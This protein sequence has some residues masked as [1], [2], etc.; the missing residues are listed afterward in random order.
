MN[1]VLFRKRLALVGIFLV[2]FFGATAQTVPTGYAVSTLSAPVTN[3]FTTQLTV[4]QANGDLYYSDNL[5]GVLRKIPLGGTSVIVNNSWSTG[6]PFSA[7]DIQYHYDNVLGGAVYMARG[8]EVVR[9]STDYNG[10]YAVAVGSFGNESGS[11]LIG[12]LLYVSDGDH[13]SNT[14]TTVDLTTNSVS[15]LT[16]G[17]LPTFSY[18]SLEYCQA[19]NTLYYGGSNWPTGNLYSVDQTTGVPT[20]ISTSLSSGPGN[21]AVDP[22]GKYAYTADLSGDINRIDLVTG[23]SSPFATG[24]SSNTYALAFGPALGGGYNLYMTT[25]TS[26]IYQISGFG[27]SALNFDGVNDYVISASPIGITGNQPRTVEYWATLNNAYNHHVN[28]GSTTDN[29][30]FG[31]Y[32]TGGFLHFYCFGVTGTF[33][34]NTGFAADNA[35]HHV[36]VT[37]DGTTVRTYVDGLPTPFPTA[38][39]NLTTANGPVYIGV[40]ED[41]SAVTFTNSTIEDVR[42]WNRALCQ[43]EIQAH[44]SCELTG[45]ETGL[46]LYYKFNDGNP[47]ANNAGVTTANDNSPSNNDG[48]LNGPFTLNGTASNWVDATVAGSC[49]AFVAPVATPSSNSP[50]CTGNTINLSADPVTGA[51]YSWTGPNAF[52]SSLQNPTI[53]PATLAD[54]GTYSLTITVAGCTSAVSTT[55]VIVN[56]VPA[57]PTAANDGPVCEGATFNLSTPTV[58]GA[59]YLWTGPNGFTSLDQNPVVTNATPLMS[60]TY[61][62]TVTVA[63]CTSAAGTTNLTVNPT[64]ATPAPSSN[65]PVCTGNTIN[66]STAAVAGATYSW[67]GPNGFTSSLQNPSITNATAA[68]AGTYFVTVTVLGCTSAAGSTTVVVN[69]TPA[70]PT[71]S[72][73]TPVCTGNTINLSTPAVAGATYSWTGPSAFASALQNPT[74]TNATVAMAGTYSVTV[75][76]SGC[77]SAVGTTAVVVNAT[78]ATPA[79]SSNTPV[80]TGNTI[81]L[82][83]SAVA[84]ATYSWTGP[85]SFASSVQNPSITNAT[86]AMAGTYSVTVTVNGC[87]SAVGTTAVVIN[88]TPA[89]PTASS[90]TPVCTGNTINLSTPAV[91]GATYSWT[92]P[93]AFASALQN[94]TRTNATLAMAGTYSVTVTVTGCTSAVGT[95]AVVVNPTPATPA[96]SSNTPVCTGN[97]INLSTSAVAGATYSWT[98]PNSFVSSVQN[99]SITNATVAM[100]G[101][102]SVTVTVNGCTSAVGT[103]AVVVNPTPATPT[104]SSN[105]P[106]CTGNTIN[107]STP[108]VAGATYSWTGPNSFASSVQNPS[109]T[110]ATLA[111]GGTYSVTVTVTGCTSAIGTTA[112]VVNPTPATPAPSSNTPV[113]TG[114]TIN[115]ST[116]AVAGATY[117]WTGPNSFVSSVQNPSITNATL[118][119]AG[120]YSLTVTVNGCT[121]AVGTTAVVINPTPATPPAAS[122][123]PV[124]SGNTIN[125]ST[126]AVAGATYSWTGPNSFASSV[127]NP[128]ITNATVA[129]SGTYSIT[130]TV[131]GCTSAVGTTGVVVNQTPA[132]PTPSSNTPVCENS[133]INLSTAAVAGATYSWTGPNGFSSSLQNPTISPAT[134][135]DAGT[136]SLTITV[137]GCT[138]PVGTTNV[139]VTTLPVLTSSLTPAAICNGTLFSYTSTSSISGTTFTWTRAS[140]ASINGGAAG[141]G[142]NATIGEV[143]TNSSTAPV[144]VVYAVTMTVNG[145]SNTQN[146]TVSVNPTPVLTSASSMPAICSGGTTSYAPTSSTT[147]V[148]FSWSRAAVTGISTLA[149]SGTGNP[150]EVLVNTT[151]NPITVTYVYSLS[152]NGCVSS[153]PYNVTVVVNPTPVLSS[154]TNAGAICSGNTFAYTPASTTSGATF[155]W[156]RAIVAGITEAGTAG[157]GSVSETLTNTTSAPITVTYVYTLTANG[158]P[159]TSYNITVVVNP[160]PTLTNAGAAP[161]ICSNNTF[162]FVPAS[163]VSGATFNWT[164]AAVAGISNGASSGSGN[165]NEVLINTTNAAVT[166]TYIYTVSTN[167]CNS[168]PANVTVVVNP[169][170]A[171]TSTLTP[172]AI[173]NNTVFIYPATSNI[174]GATINWSR[175]AVAGISNLAATGT[176][177]PNETL[178]NTTGAPVVVTYV[179]TVSAN[180]CNSSAYNVTVTVNPTPVLST[181]Q[182]PP[183]ICSNTTFSYAPASTTGGTVF[184][185]SRA[186][187]VG[188]SNGAA[189][190]SGNPMETLVNITTAPVTV[191][192]VYTLTAN[193]CSNVQNVTVVVNPTPV[194]STPLTIAAIC[195]GAT[196]NYS[197]ASSTTGATFSWTRAANPSINGG[198]GGS[199]ANNT[200]SETL[201]NSTNAPVIVSYVF[202]I[203]ANGCSNTQ[204]VTIQVNPSVTLTSTTTPPA[205]CDNALF[206]YVPTSAVTGATFAWSRAAVTNIANLAASG[207]GNP[208]EN[209]DNTGTAPVVVT[210]VYIVTAN[211]CS[212]AP[213]SV[214]VTVNPT[215]VLTSITSAPAICSGINFSYAPTSSTTGTTFNWSR[216]AVTG[217]S[218]TSAAGTGNPNEVLT[219]TTANPVVVT[220]VYSLS[221]NGC[222]NPLTYNVTVTV[223]PTPVLTSTQTPPAVCNNTTFNYTP[224]SSTTGATFAWSRAA[225]AG[226][227]NATASGSGNPAEV[228]VNNINTPVNVTYVYTITANGCTSIPY[229]VV[230]TVNPT[231]NLTSTPTPPAICNNTVFSYAPASNVTG[232]T[233]A[234]TR[235][236]VV[237]ISNPANSGSG[238]PLETLINTSTAPVT[239]TYVY[240]A[241]AY[242]CS[243]T[244]T[245]VT[246]VVNPNPVLTS[247]QAPAAICNNTTFNYTPTSGVTSTTFAWS[248]AVVPGISNGAA[249]GSG[250][251]AEV[252]VNTTN[253]PVNVT[254]VYTLSA[255]GCTNPT[256]YNVVVTVNPTPTLT[257]TL[258][259]PA[260]CDNATFS[261]V[262]TSAVAGAT[263]AWSR[264]ALTGIA[265][266]AATGTGNPLEALDNTGTAPVV[267]TYVYTVTANGC[268]SSLYNV[269]VTVNPTPAL[270][271]TVTPPAICSGTNFSYTPTSG[272]TG[273]TFSWSRAAVTGISNTSAAGTGNP[274]EVLTNTSANPVNVTYVYSLSA[275]GCANTTT[276]NVVVTVNPSPILTSTLA[277][278]AICSGT[279]FSYTPTSTTTGVTFNWSRAAVAGITN[280]AATGVGNPNEALNNN[281]TAIVNVTYVYTVVINGCSSPAYN[282]V[283]PVKPIPAL[284]SITTP[285]AICNNAV[286]N[287]TPTSGVTGATFAWSRAAVAGISNGAATGTGNPAEQLL[288]TTVAPITVTYVYT[289]SANGCNSPLTNVTV[290][291]NPTPTLTSTTTPPAICN[292]TTFNYTP[293]SGTT[294]TTFNWS[295]AAIAGIANTASSGSGNPAEVLVNTT[296]APINVTYVYTLSANSCANPATYSVVVT[297]NPAPALTSTLTPAAICNNTAFSYV[298]TSSTTGATFAWSRAAVAGIS[299]GAATGTGNPN[300]TLVN[301]TAASVNVTYVYTLTANG[302]TN[303]T[304]Y[305]VVVTVRPNPLMTSPLTMPAIC[306]NTTFNYSPTSSTSGATF[307]WSRA[308]VPGIANVA[309]TGVGNPAEVLI[310][311]TTT[312]VTVTY[313]YTISA[314][315]CSNPVP[316]SVTVVV[317]PVPTMTST[318]TPP[319]ICNNGTFSY[320]PTSASTGV[321]FAWS[322]NIVAGISNLAASGTGN[323]NEVLVNTTPNPINVTYAYTLSANGCTNPSVYNVVVTVYPTPLLTSTLTPPAICH[324]T[325]FSYVP[326]SLTPGTTFA[327]S[328]AAV[329]GINGNTPGSGFGN[330]NEMLANSTS[331]P[332]TVNYVYTLSANG[333]TNPATYTVS[334][335]V[336]PLP[337]LTS[338]LAPADVCDSNVFNYI[339][340]SPTVGTIFTWSRAAVAGI[341]NPMATGTGNPA[342]TLYNTTPDPVDVTY[343]YVLSINGCNNPITY[344][345]VVTVN[346]TPMLSTPLNLASQCN[347][348]TF[349][350]TPASPTT[351]TTFSWSRAAI[352]GIANAPATGTNGINE[353][354]MNNSPD[355]VQVVYQYSLTANGCTHT[356]LVAVWVKPTPLLTSPLD[357]GSVCNNTT[358]TYTPT[359]LTVGTAFAWTRA[360]VNNISNPAASGTGDPNEVLVNT[361]T[362]TVHV[363]YTYTLS[364]YGCTNPTT[365][366]VVVVVNPDAQLTSTLTPAAICDS[367]VFDY[368]P[369]SLTPGTTFAWTRATVA[370]IANAAG[371]GSG[372]PME[373]LDNQTADPITVTYIYTLTAYGCTNPTTYSVDV[374][375]NPTP[376]LNTTLTPAAICNNTVF[377]YIPGSNTV[378]TTFAWSRA[379]IIGISNAAATG[380]GDPNETLENTT[381]AP[382]DVMYEYT[383]TANG[384]SHVQTVTVTVYPSVTVANA[385][386]DIGPLNATA[387]LLNA[388]QPVVGT[389]NW[390]FT[391]GPNTPVIVDPT[392]FNTEVNTLIPGTYTFVWTITSPWNCPQSTDTMMVIINNPPVA[393]NDSAS[394]NMNVGVAI[395]LTN[396]D[397]DSDGT[398]NVATIDVI[399][400]P[401]HGTLNVGLTGSVFYTPNTNFIGLDNFTYTVRDNDNGVSNIA[402]VVISVYERP[403]AVDDDTMTMTNIAVDIDVLSNDVLGSAPLDPTTVD[404]IT[405]PTHGSAVPTLSGL[406][407]YVPD[408][409]Y[410]GTDHF[411]YSVRDTFNSL[412]DTANVTVRIYKAP[413][414]VNDDVF[415]DEDIPVVI[416][417]VAN[418]TSFGIGLNKASIVVTTQP[419]HGSVQ[420]HTDGTAT[421]SPAIGYFGT[422]SYYYTVKDDNGFVSNVAKVTITIISNK[423]DL[424]VMKTVTTP[425]EKI[426]VGED[427]EFNV[428]VA[429]S[430]KLDATNVVVTDILA[431]NLGGK[432]V[433]LIA[434]VGTAVYDENTKTITWTIPKVAKGE[435]YA[436]RAIM[437]VTSGGDIINIATAKCTEEETIVNNNASTAVVDMSGREDLF[438]PNVITV[439]G[440]GKNDNFMVL[441]LYKYPNAE[442]M[443]FN[444]WGNMV[445]ESKDYKNNWDGIG[446]NEGTYYYV[447]KVNKYGM[448]KEYS[449]W[450]QVLR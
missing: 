290:V 291:V 57:T 342:E 396:N 197:A 413:I 110:N 326:T 303:P 399:T 334:V 321:A 214:T 294:G 207:S 36:A 364:A 319:A 161:A 433:R 126:P 338:T 353:V 377:N 88:A 279:T 206:G 27:N 269:A 89:T 109:I 300:E 33:D 184:N 307:S 135:A 427:I 231:V 372:N 137:L 335:V 402:N 302:C 318:L 226:I 301:T 160:I 235:A 132:A 229:N 317:N 165:P 271:S 21:F 56:A 286:F 449:G 378:G 262:P 24:F 116:A 425:L 119:M 190:G 407:H 382:I 330:P 30:A 121:S 52:S 272:T 450:V 5:S 357:A 385:G 145:C 118:A 322:R 441:G 415:T 222:T 186:T 202:T 72:S 400:N 324:N 344:N 325:P 201:T 343:V 34:H 406:V 348:L 194:L 127:Q 151:A 129:M 10:N 55:P 362:D 215:P 419:A 64:P 124:C 398:I 298:P 106:V 147:G 327:W 112:V 333:C 143:L 97:T 69:A 103:T 4:N 445:Y 429:N 189:T 380:T 410:Y 273:T 104:A 422:D 13:S 242:G 358:F 220:Y 420:I 175:A 139:S 287:Y 355:S 87:T 259:P 152:I 42:I 8:N 59:T 282:V 293:T 251:P 11:A 339:P 183:A 280:T 234:W 352:A 257:S 368:T 1:V 232:A 306:S 329:A 341:G 131:T 423:P 277:P 162:S 95:T 191:T 111:M 141:S 253:N 168:A 181:T 285:S 284:T 361:G 261:Y 438:I 208:N 163:A 9:G 81:N 268:V 359:S 281:T 60:G 323:P 248:R 349:A 216:A 403:N 167:G 227:T 292:N 315:G 255:N 310:N 283:V 14:I 150:G 58:G 15:T 239:V 157:A 350:Y 266:A 66:L 155:S 275:N 74:R 146:V 172:A 212:S 84:G 158:C 174:G 397:T 430:G 299:N 20:L 37:Y 332:I 356:E 86:V 379:A 77:T 125:L 193:G 267:V 247:T 83:T 187:V 295:R 177:S 390:S 29:D 169:T 244:P 154:P 421:Y 23:V 314:N 254:Y 17:A 180:G 370:G 223:N 313:V 73:N 39:R 393:N 128:S 82:S 354:L 394:T 274:N 205:I 331:A 311:N 114:N 134:L 3:S 312:P 225:V 436:L 130:V 278:A 94:P 47:N 38:A 369:T 19:N 408:P 68:E 113:C 387:T 31:M 363:T 85:N 347:N 79:P 405:H 426:A 417:M 440:D 92:G 149:A 209:L 384:C 166:V 256:T 360:V 316:Y 80:C 296:A 98:G 224:T 105:T 381:T 182:T 203:T 44:M 391:T 288:N 444:R 240:T 122:N 210:Y 263:F 228:L 188:I 18:E 90:N 144:N 71:A 107:L 446:L 22:F 28:W 65:T 140:I 289:V 96:P 93:S 439:N 376:Y 443:V 91:A 386:T 76:V 270:T 404:V 195:S 45:T 123:T 108:A 320:T 409:G 6:H 328:R 218:N 164:R 171:L 265:N 383:M 2:S 434:E 48:T 264:A 43:G 237:G 46:V 217:I 102:Y 173:C 196:A 258:A 70:T 136:Y 241:S 236:T 366:D 179:Y 133:A 340:T 260:I 373:T 62:V 200:I 204:T 249:T 41:L 401:S 199:G 213:T 211:G 448:L 159:G 432:N 411:T 32:M 418:D 120:T 442:F 185:W 351:G 243:G 170:P 305:N 412:S 221:A 416:D 67:T 148:V 100:A 336:N 219:N 26:S 198:V 153:T 395:N 54:A 53:S 246:V 16:V 75:T 178:I 276:Y 78:P 138:G 346:P 156:S 176:N 367:T 308:S 414:A 7:T 61:S 238:N 345:V 435:S 250:N 245:N 447:L 233:F 252:L 337:I 192:Y 309:A 25:T 12:N 424:M 142:S 99:P 375:V 51:T 374:V 392:L 115:L 304:T 389:G 428:T 371:A 35:Y 437:Q 117:S 297:V 365:Y 101:T 388:N 63:G 230:V 50:V 40:R 49:A 431:E